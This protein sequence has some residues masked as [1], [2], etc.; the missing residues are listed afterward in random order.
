M[1]CRFRNCANKRFLISSGKNV[2]IEGE[3]IQKTRETGPIMPLYVRD[4]DQNLV[5]IYKKYNFII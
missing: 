2:V 4:R 5:E 1:N 3:P